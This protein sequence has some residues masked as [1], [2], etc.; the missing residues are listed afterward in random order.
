MGHVPCDVWDYTPR[1]IAGFLSVAHTR[2][3]REKADSLALQALAARG[4]PT[5]VKRQHKE[6]L[7]KLMNQ[8]HMCVNVARETSRLD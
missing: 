5:E 7:Q 4:E 8:N 1:R 3:S 2:L 6:L